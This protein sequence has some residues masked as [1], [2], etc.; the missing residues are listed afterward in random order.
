MSEI[1][2]NFHFLR[3]YMLSMLLLLVPVYYWGNKRVTKNSAWLKVCDEHLFNFL[4][5][6][7][8]E[9]SI[10]NINKLMFLI[11]FFVSVAVAGPAWKKQNAAAL[12][13]D[14]PVMI[15]L[16]MSSDMQKTDVSPSRM[17]RAKFIIKDLMDEIQ[18]SQTGLMVYSR[19]PFTVLPLSDDSA[20]VENLLPAIDFDIMPE[21]GDRLDR[22]VDMAVNRLK[23]AGYTEGNIVVLA[24]D[25]GEHFD[26]ALES[27]KKASADKFTVNTVNIGNGG[28]DKLKLV[29]ENGRG[30]Y[31]EYNQDLNKLLSLLNRKAGENIKESENEQSVWPDYG[32]YF[33]FLPIFLALFLF[34]RG[35]FV[36]ALIVFFVSDAYAGWFL[37]DNQEAK[38]YF[39]AADYE[40]AAKIF[41]DEQWRGAAEYKKG[42]Y[43]AALR[44]FEKKND[45]ESLYNQGNAL[46]KSGKTDE[47]IKKYE[48][49]LKLEPNHEDGKFNLEYLKKQQSQSEQQQSQ[50]EQQQSQSEQQQSQSEQQQSQSKQQ[51]SQSEQQQSQSEQQQSQSEQQ[52]SQSEQQQSQSEQQQSQSE[53]Q[54]SQSEQQQSQSERQQSQSNAT[55]DKTDKEH[56]SDN[57]MMQNSENS[58]KEETQN[59]EAVAGGSDVNSQEK[60]KIRA[61]MQKF[62]EI[63]EDKG[64]L[65]RA[66]IR[67]EYENNRYKD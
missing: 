2:H 19:E 49:V 7:N 26:M 51:Q 31:S 60:E 34:R 30:L 65:L 24:S 45:V 58:E 40:N 53:Q 22:A 42:D 50:S 21:N 62:R 35:L 54:Q 6:K 33:L 37:N 67:K 5:V 4:K 52:Q 46:A 11:I 55:G 38:R 17:E 13:S 1:L 43:E 47:A 27:A 48:E 59:S 29:A 25:V 3:P 63:P 14:N 15:V 23:D 57:S 61:K 36:G 39:D 44:E 28:S 10:K 20:L 41:K 56:N 66:F 18:D 32:Y 12:I 8:Q 16:S 9:K 64:G